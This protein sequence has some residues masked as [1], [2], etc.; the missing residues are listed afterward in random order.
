[1]LRHL[2]LGLLR[3]G[4]PR[5]G[6]GLMSEYRLRAGE[7]L[8]MG[9]L[10]RE[11]ARM[12]KEALVQAGVNPPEAD[13]RRIPYQIT[14]R[15]R[16]AFDAWFLAPVRDEDEIAERLVFVDSAPAEGLA[17][18]LDRW[19]GDLWSRA[20]ALT[21]TREDVLNVG[22]YGSS[23]TAVPALLS[24]QLKHLTAELEFVKELRT[25]LDAWLARERA[26]AANPFAIAPAVERAATKRDRRPG[27]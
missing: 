1:M 15:G 9:N 11:V 17:R 4:N 22:P 16:Q 21:R 27:G 12:L 18:L 14:D 19:Q 5:H 8:S 3:D 10:Y 7:Q 23:F 6:Y 13:A 20:K 25:D 26:L 2:I 24:R